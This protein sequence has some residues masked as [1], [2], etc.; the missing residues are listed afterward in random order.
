[1]KWA[2]IVA[3]G[4]DDPAIEITIEGTEV[5]LILSLLVSL[6]AECFSDITDDTTRDE[7]EAVRDALIEK[8]SQ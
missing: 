1:M 8:V 4:A 2:S 7:F 6:R 3:I 5:Q